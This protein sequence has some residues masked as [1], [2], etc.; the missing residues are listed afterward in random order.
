MG[1]IHSTRFLHGYGDNS[2]TSYT[3]PAGHI[4]LVR[5]LAVSNYSGTGGTIEVGAGG[6]HAFRRILPAS[7]G[8][9][10]DELRLVAYAGEVVFVQTGPGDLRY[11]L[12]GFLLESSTGQLGEQKP[13]VPKPA[14]G[15]LE[16]A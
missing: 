7:S 4:A 6:I 11:H 9:S 14:P 8:G 5:G 10:W 1:R 15:A 16:A 2:A 12:A 3:V 13:A